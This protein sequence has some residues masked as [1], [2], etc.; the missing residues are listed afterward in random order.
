MTAIVDL[1]AVRRS[2]LELPKAHLHVHL[3]GCMRPAS[4]VERADHYGLEVPT[5]TGFG[6]FTA[7]S[8]MY[9]AAAGVIRTPDD[10]ARLVNEVVEDAALDGAVWVEPC[11]Q[12]RM[13]ADTLGGLEAV[14]DIMVDAMQDAAA[15]NGIGVGLIVSA[16]RTHD[17][18][19]AVENARL[20]VRYADRGVV[21]F[22]LGNDEVIGPPEW[23]AEAFSI[24]RAGGLLSAPHAGE[25]V[26]PESILAALDVLG[27]D[28]ILHGVR[29]TE[30]ESLMQRLA[31]EQIC[32]DV[33]PT[34]NLLL[35]VVESYED[36]QLATLL[37]AGIPCS[38]NAD[39]SL[40]FGPGLLDEYELCRETFGFD[41]E[42]M[43]VIARSSIVG[44]AASDSFKA[45]ALAEIDRW[46]LAIDV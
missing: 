12:P 5:T 14:L 27:A 22:G 7:F 13:H 40:L 4:L 25:L 10:L 15:A 24:A 39:D 45:H 1:P 34:S 46:L 8:K 29:A 44:S 33:C 37:D 21:G 19:L 26:G 6:D 28:R 3:E 35:G 11:F 16:D 17:P 30:D 41:D 9:R 36:H 31:A 2:L 43:A 20:A 23:F 18:A 32:L 38:V 42:R